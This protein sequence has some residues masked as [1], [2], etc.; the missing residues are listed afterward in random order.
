MKIVVA[1][2]LWAVLASAATQAVGAAAV[3]ASGKI[4]APP[5]VTSRDTGWLEHPAGT[6]AIADMNVNGSGPGSKQFYGTLWVSSR[7]GDLQ[8]SGNASVTNDG[9]AGAFQW[10]APGT[11]VGG[12][13]NGWFVDTLTVR[14]DTL[15][16]GT[17][18]TVTATLQFVGSFDHT[19]ERAAGNYVDLSGGLVVE[20]VHPTHTWLGVGT[21]S[22]R[23]LDM[24]QAG[25]FPSFVGATFGIQGWLWVS[26]GADVNYLDMVSTS[27][28]SY[29]AQVRTSLSAGPTAYITAASGTI[30]APV[31]EAP[32]VAM[33]LAGLWVV[34]SR[35]WRPSSARWRRP[36][37]RSWPAAA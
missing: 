34:G 4:T 10:H 27:T 9:S 13:P 22:F 28:F 32:T 11:A 18:V 23:A 26:A 14:S 25:T 29:S 37:S 8:A 31:P 1:C 2:V 5:A 35:V 24:Q 12:E 16:L 3:R 33:L 19:F 36:A 7:Y 21:S 17:P 30:Y 6:A 20:P 15:P